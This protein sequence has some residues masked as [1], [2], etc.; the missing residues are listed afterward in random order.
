MSLE[1]KIETLSVL[2]GELIKTLDK[3]ATLSVA[4]PA[5]VAPAPEPAAAPV[6]APAPDPV[7]P[8]P[9]AVSPAAPVMP[10]P[11]EF[12]SAPAAPAAVP[13]TDSASLV[14]YVMGVY[15]QIGPTKGAGI[16]D[17]LT[18]VGAVNL[19]D[20]KPE[21]YAAFYAGIEALKG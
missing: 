15:R 20:V 6:A 18:S 11:P 21:Q 7:A 2:I 16:Q 5:P 19:T 10:P 8:A 3:N 9:V 14:A 4:A 13:F 17:V 12:T 1:T